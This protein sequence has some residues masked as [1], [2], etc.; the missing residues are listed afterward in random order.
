L[1]LLKSSLGNI[2]VIEIT[3]ATNMSANTSANVKP[4]VKSSRSEA[5]YTAEMMKPNIEISIKVPGKGAI[6]Y[7]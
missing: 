2:G 4:Q 3:E 6:L 5:V 1:L 7:I